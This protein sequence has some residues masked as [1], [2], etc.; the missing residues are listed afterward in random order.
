MKR[1]AV[2]AAALAGLGGRSAIAVM[3]AWVVLGSAGAVI[4]NPTW[5]GMLGALIIGPAAL[6]MSILAVAGRSDPMPA[7]SAWLAVVLALLVAVSESWVIE[8][9][10]RQPRWTWV[11]TVAMMSVL[12]V[13]GRIVAAVAGH[14]VASLAH[15]L[16]P[17]VAGDGWRGSI[18]SLLIWTSCLFAIGI[19]FALT[20]RAHSR[21]ISRLRVAGEA[22]AAERAAV[23]ARA[24]ESTRLVAELERIAVP[25]LERIASGGP[26][27][28]AER[29]DILLVEATL[30]D[31]VRARILASDVVLEAAT[32]ARRTGVEVVLLD[33]GGLAGA[34]SGTVEAMHALVARVLD[35]QR[36]GTVTVRV[37]PPGRKHA[38][39]IVSTSTSGTRRITVR[40]GAPIQIEQQVEGPACR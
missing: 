39:S 24:L 17:V 14:V 27:D 16:M 28:R 35:E 36:D 40:R 8:M 30:R 32:R 38:C 19:C 3:V 5:L 2:S 11:V 12:V 9:D 13:R 21:R 37:V 23:E 22:L 18:A 34:G 20:L 1:E 26:L 4:A 10:G 25:R 29:E 33:D 31:R 15:A 6:A 7:L